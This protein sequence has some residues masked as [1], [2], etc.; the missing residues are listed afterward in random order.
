MQFSDRYR[1]GFEFG[2]EVVK[3]FPAEASGGL[4]ALKAMSAP[5]GM[6]KFIPTGGINTKNLNSYL[7]FNKILACGG[8]WMVDQKSISH[9]EILKK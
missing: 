5:Y 4:A 9:P 2:L 3:F 6:I 8:S 1:D 7:D